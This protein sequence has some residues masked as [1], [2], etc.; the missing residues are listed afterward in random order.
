MCGYPVI[1]SDLLFQGPTTP[2]SGLLIN[3]AGLAFAPVS[4]LMHLAD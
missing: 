4:D 3:I 1:K 2:I